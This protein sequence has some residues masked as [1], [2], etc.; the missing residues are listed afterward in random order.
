VGDEHGGDPLLVVQAAQPFAQL[1]PDGGV[2]GPEGLVEQQHPRF[3]GERSRQRH[4]LALTSGELRRP[5]L[6]PFREAHQGQ[7]L[8]HAFADLVS[9]PLADPQTEGDV[10][11]HAHVGEG[12][13]VLEHEADAA[14]LGTHSLTSAPSMR[15]VPESGSQARR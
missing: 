7:Q 2:E 5:L 10:L 1:R 6:R 13:V 14:L 8:I 4:P 15:T 9:R 11:A 12:G 3:D